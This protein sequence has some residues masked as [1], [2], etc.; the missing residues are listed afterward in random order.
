MWLEVEEFSRTL[1]HSNGVRKHNAATAV[2]GQEPEPP[3]GSSGA[4]YAPEDQGTGTLTKG[5]G[6]VGVSSPPVARSTS[7]MEM[8]RDVVMCRPSAKIT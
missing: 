6:T 7:A 2:A 5:E 4:V 3:N 8:V 1:V